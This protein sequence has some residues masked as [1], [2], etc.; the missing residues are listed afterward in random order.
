MATDSSNMTRILITGGAGLLGRALIATAPPNVDLH[1]TQRHTPVR[2]AEAHPLD[3]ADEP[4]TLALWESLRPDLV[5]H[6]AFTQNEGERDIWAA[7][8][9]VVAACHAVGAALIH[10]SSDALLDGEHAPYAESADP[11]PVHEYGRW[12]AKAEW[13]VREQMAD[14]AIV[15]TSLITEFA[16]LDPRSAWVAD[17]LRAGKPITLFVDELRCPIAPRDL[18]MQLWEIAALPA[19]ERGGTWHLVGPEAL[20]RY[21]LGLLIAA[22]EGLDP[23]GIT[24]AR[25]AD[26]PMPRPRDL[27]LLT[28]RADR[29]LKTRAQAISA[30]MVKK[31]TEQGR[32]EHLGAR[33]HAFG[34]ALQ[35][36]LAIAALLNARGG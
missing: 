13:H 34:R 28:A 30:L 22:H 29:A 17:S 32:R 9:N 4:A 12:K 31:A 19:S 35:T 15:R 8:R 7:T 1:A 36:D 16:P 6:T 33:R 25:S 20:S 27:R 24:P 11:A 23:S 3:L 26:F 2:G 10:L 21:A 5:I 14:A 18:A